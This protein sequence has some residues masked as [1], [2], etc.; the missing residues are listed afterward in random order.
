VNENICGDYQLERNSMG[1]SIRRSDKSA[2]EV[3]DF[4]ATGTKQHELPVP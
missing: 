2:V 1:A 4:G 3:E